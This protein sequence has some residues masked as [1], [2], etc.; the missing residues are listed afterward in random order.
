M[1]TNHLYHTWEQELRELRPTEHRARLRTFIWL[2][3]GLFLSRSVHLK[4]IAKKIPGRAT[5]NSKTRRV[6]RLLDTSALRVRSWYKPLAQRLLQEIHDHGLEIRLLVDGSKVGFNHQLLMVAV[7]YRRRALP[8]AWTWINS[9]RGHSSGWKQ[10]ALLAYVEQLLPPG[11]QVSLVGDCEFGAGPILQWLDKLKWHYALR[12]PGNR[13]VKLPGHSTWQRLDTLLHRPRQRLWL[14][15]VRLTEKHAYAVSLAAYWKAGE[16]QPW[17]LATNY[18]TLRT[19]LR[20]YRKRMW[21]E[22]M[23]GDFKGHG[24]DL[25]TSQL[26]H[27]LRLSRLT[28]AVVLLYLWLIAYGSKVIKDGQRYLV[29][30]KDRRDLSIFRIGLDMLDR[31]LTNQ[32]PFIFRWIPYF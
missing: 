13:L 4:E 28:L 29:D 24:F 21:I 1:S 12:Q 30:R 8:L 32:E 9:A 25:E 26:R 16:E 7:A 27:F 6:R 19:A 11:A 5:N 17:L 18:P 22:E 14:P 10:L 20:A 2:L 15:Q 23:F 31:H 3:L